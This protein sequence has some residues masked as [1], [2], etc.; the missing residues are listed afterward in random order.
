MCVRQNGG[1]MEEK[2][3]HQSYTK[4]QYMAAMEKSEVRRE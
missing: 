1:M 3:V 2:H 4:R